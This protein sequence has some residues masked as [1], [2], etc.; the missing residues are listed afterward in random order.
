MIKIDIVIA[1]FSRLNIVED[2][3]KTILANFSGFIGKIIIVDSTNS[4]FINTEI[5]K[6]KLYIYTEH[7]NQPYQRYLGFL[8]SESDYILFLDDDM[9]INDKSFFDKL[10]SFIN[11]NK[12]LIGINIPFINNNAFIGSFENSE[13]LIKRKTKA[14]ANLIGNPFINSNSFVFCG[15]KG[16]LEFGLDVE[17]LCGG[18]FLIKRD[19]IYSNFNMQLFELYKKQLG[20]GEDGVLGYTISKIGKIGILPDCS[21]IHNDYKESSYSSSYFKFNSRVMYSRLFLSCEYYRLNNKNCF[22]GYLRYHH[23][24]IFRI[25]GQL[26]RTLYSPNFKN[27]GCL[28]GYLWGYFLSLFFMFDYNLNNNSFWISEA[29]NDLN[30]NG[31]LVK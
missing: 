28:N 14:I 8:A 11:E 10:F 4:E 9:E 21:L 12:S 26:F 7:K 31:Y 2:F 6:N 22:K 15:I 24:A 17:Y 18:A 5:N 16:P 20:K 23:Y 13:K 19:S 27:W 25:F 3:S 1:T 29:K 30:R